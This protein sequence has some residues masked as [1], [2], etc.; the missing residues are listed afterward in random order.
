MAKQLVS[1][2]PEILSAFAYWLC[3][4]T[5]ILASVGLTFVMFD[6]ETTASSQSGF[7]SPYFSV[8]TMMIYLWQFIIL[9]SKLSLRQ[10]SAAFALVLGT[11]IPFIYWKCMVLRTVESG[12]LGHLLGN[13]IWVLPVPVV[14]FFMFSRKSLDDLSEFQLGG[15]VLLVFVALFVW[16]AVVSLTLVLTGLAPNWEVYFT[17]C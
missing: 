11:A 6:S 9:R 8:I 17:S 14:T 2:N 5:G 15:F 10:K 4:A 13:P 3:L 12:T 16:T 7:F 1:T